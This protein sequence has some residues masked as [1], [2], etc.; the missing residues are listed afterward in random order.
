MHVYNTDTMQ[1]VLKL[2]TE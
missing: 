1:N 2:T